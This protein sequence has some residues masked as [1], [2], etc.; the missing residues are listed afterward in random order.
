MATINVDAAA[1]ALFDQHKPTLELLSAIGVRDSELQ[2][3]IRAAVFAETAG[4]SAINDGDG[5]KAGE[6]A[7]EA[8]ADYV[9]VLMPQDSLPG[10]C[11]WYVTACMS[12]VVCWV[13]IGVCVCACVCVSSQHSFFVYDYDAGTTR[14]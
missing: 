14:R 3:T 11:R 9:R 10:V 7:F 13:R 12:Y 4:W 6:G 1:A 8:A 5:A 2:N